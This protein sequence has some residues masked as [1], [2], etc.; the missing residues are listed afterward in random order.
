MARVKKKKE[1]ETNLGHVGEELFKIVEI[2]VGTRELGLD[3]LPDP[4][5]E[6]RD[7]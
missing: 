2:Q 7:T 3:E 6:S 1:K 5:K 4:L